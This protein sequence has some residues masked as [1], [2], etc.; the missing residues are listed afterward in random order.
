M[1]WDH[2][3]AKNSVGTGPGPEILSSIPPP[4][5]IGEKASYGSD[6]DSINDKDRILTDGKFGANADQSL[7]A[8]GERLTFGC[9]IDWIDLFGK[10]EKFKLYETMRNL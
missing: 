9:S 3:W 1:W 10:S 6:W 5:V 7:R 2:A 4:D 8:Y